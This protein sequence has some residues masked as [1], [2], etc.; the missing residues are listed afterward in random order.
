MG[1]S[2]L[3]RAGGQKTN[4]QERLMIFTKDR[5]RT[6]QQGRGFIENNVSTDVGLTI[7]RNRGVDN[8]CSWCQR[9]VGLRAQLIMGE[10]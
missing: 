5:E 10:E 3:E 4:F 1:Y 6:Q 7:N 2:Y 8:Q 9:S